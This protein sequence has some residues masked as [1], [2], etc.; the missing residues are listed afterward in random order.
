MRLL[1]VVRVFRR[2]CLKYLVENLLIASQFFQQYARL[3][4]DRIQ[5][6]RAEVSALRY[7]VTNTLLHT[8]VRVRSI[9]FRRFGCIWNVGALIT[10]LL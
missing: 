7:F 1:L 6:L 5:M 9:R 8:R 2:C 4:L 10:D 3:H